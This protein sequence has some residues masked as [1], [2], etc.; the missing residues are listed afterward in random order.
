MD[1]TD[2]DIL[3]MTELLQSKED[4]FNYQKILIER[5]NGT[6][7]SFMLNIAGEEKLNKDIIKFHK[8]YREIIKNTILQVGKIY[9]SDYFE[10]KTGIES[11]F[12]TDIDPIKLKKMMVAIENKNLETR[13]LDIDIFSKD[14]KNITRK[15]LN[16]E[17]RKCLIC[18]KDAKVC[19]R[20][21]NHDLNE[22]LKIQSSILKSK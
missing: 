10:K 1:Y 6:L 7:L 8:K 12:V 19:I 5:Y 21:N 13:F 22:I 4:R 11:Y 14:F 2:S 17:N 3:R 16:L 18:N 15:T 20:E 9:F